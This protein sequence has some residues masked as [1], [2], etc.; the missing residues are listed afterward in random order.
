MAKRA[1]PIKYLLGDKNPLKKYG[2]A[3]D[4]FKEKA[5]VTVIQGEPAFVSVVCIKRLMIHIVIKTRDFFKGTNH[6]DDW[7]FITTP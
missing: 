4:G 3:K 1:L 5:W 2:S 7:L 6:E